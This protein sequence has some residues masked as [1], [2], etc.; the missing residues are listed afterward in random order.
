MV[1]YVF[2]LM[3][4]FKT[5]IQNEEGREMMND[6]LMFLE[7][8]KYLSL[9]PGKSFQKNENAIAIYKMFFEKSRRYY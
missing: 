4:K 7:V 2:R 6:L 5:Y 3:S 9:G 8:E 1:K